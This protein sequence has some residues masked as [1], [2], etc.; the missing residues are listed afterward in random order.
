LG[1]YDV[2]AG[3]LIEELA[4]EFKTKV[5]KPAFTEYAKTGS[6]RE[7]SP[8]N[9]DWFYLRMG[10]VLYRTYKDGLTGTGKLRTYYGGRKN[11][12]VRPEKKRKASGKVIRVCLQMLEKEGL[13]K[14][15]KKGRRVSAK[16]EKLLSEKAKTAQKFFEENARKVQEQEKIELEKRQQ[17]REKAAAQK[18]QETSPPRKEARPEGHKRPQ[19][20][21]ALHGPATQKNQPAL[22]GEQNQSAAQPKAEE[23]KK[24]NKQ[25]EKENAEKGNEDGRGRAEAKKA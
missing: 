21:T 1:I 22:D 24:E 15:E 20:N 17:A 18:P 25:L 19:Q 11:R 14:K 8:E 23:A 12:G 16:G 10:S 2:P 4:R 9:P 5:K 13:L 6:H 7:R 3:M